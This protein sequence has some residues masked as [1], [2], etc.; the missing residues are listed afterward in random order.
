MWVHQ[1]RNIKNDNLR[2]LFE[3]LHAS[4]MVHVC[5][6]EAYPYVITSK[7]VL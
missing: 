4:G 6:S 5:V 3:E 2:L 1:E 7:Q